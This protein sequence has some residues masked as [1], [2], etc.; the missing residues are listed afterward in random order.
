MCM[1]ITKKE[2]IFF[3]LFIL[4]V[5]VPLTTFAFGAVPFGGRITAIKAPP[6]IQC[7][8]NVNSPFTIMPVRGP[9]GPWSALP[10]Q[11]NVGQIVPNAWI[12]GLIF[13]TSGSCMT[14]TN[15]P[16]FF[17]TTTTHFYGTSIGSF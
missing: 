16:A 6:A 14:T 2:S 8:T 4:A 7:V 11:V 12:I 1:T 5:I 9:V 3:I 17:P 13:P 15:P 10:G